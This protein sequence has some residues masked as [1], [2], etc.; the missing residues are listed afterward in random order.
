[1][2][3]WLCGVPSCFSVCSGRPFL[4]GMLWKP[5]AAFTPRVNRMKYS[6]TPESSM[7]TAWREREYTAYVPGSR[8]SV[9][10]PETR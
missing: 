8:L 5:I 4:V 10:L 6:I 7:P 3:P 1:M 9:R 2:H